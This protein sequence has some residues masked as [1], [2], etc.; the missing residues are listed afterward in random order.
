[1]F[2]E[3]ELSIF[4]VCIIKNTWFVFFILEIHLD[5]MIIWSAFQPFGINWLGIPKIGQVSNSKSIRSY[6]KASLIRSKSSSLLEEL[7]KKAQSVCWGLLSSFFS[8]L[9]KA[10]RAFKAF[11][12][13]FYQFEVSLSLPLNKLFQASEICNSSIAR[14]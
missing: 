1:M 7:C 5:S 13:K 6:C 8:W 14:V 9:A 4:G 3:D 12:A 11:V 2:C 10:M